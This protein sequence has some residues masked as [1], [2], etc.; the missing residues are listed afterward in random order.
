MANV[1]PLII[2]PV[3]SAGKES[4]VT[5]VCHCRAAFMELVMRDRWNATVKMTGME[6]IVIF[7]REFFNSISIFRI[8]SC[9][10]QLIVIHVIATMVTVCNQMTACKFSKGNNLLF[11]FLKL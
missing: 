11:E 1:D 8:K 2:V 4:T 10:F 5:F 3:K 9:Y 6:L 7:V